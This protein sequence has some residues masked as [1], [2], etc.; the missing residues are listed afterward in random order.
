MLVVEENT[1]KLLHAMGD[2]QAEGRADVMER[3]GG[4]HP[5]CIPG[6]RPDRS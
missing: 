6:R 4:R 2:H 3:E 5:L 1:L